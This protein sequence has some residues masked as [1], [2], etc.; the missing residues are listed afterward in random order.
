MQGTAQN[1]SVVVEGVIESKETKLTRGKEGENGEI[2]AGSRKEFVSVEIQEDMKQYPTKVNCWDEGIKKQVANY[3]LGDYVTMYITEEKKMSNYSGQVVTYRNGVHISASSEA[4]SRGTSSDASSPKAPWKP[5]PKASPMQGFST[6]K[7][8]KDMLI[9]DQVIFKCAVKLMATSLSTKT[10][11]SPIE[12]AQLARDTWLA[13][14]G[15]HDSK[16]EVTQEPEKPLKEEDE[17]FIGDEL[18]IGDD[19]APIAQIKGDADENISG[20]SI[21]KTENS[22]SH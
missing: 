11:L 19:E 17:V 5:N 8:S 12:A 16:P 22:S 4:S 18:F 6:N 15:H 14:R 13:V 2:I 7:D 20:D 10:K 1:E 9:L 21:T 3:S